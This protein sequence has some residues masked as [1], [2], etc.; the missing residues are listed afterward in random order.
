MAQTSFGLNRTNS[1]Y[2]G[3]LRQAGRVPLPG[4]SGLGRDCGTKFYERGRRDR[5]LAPEFD[6]IEHMGEKE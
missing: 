6:P 5:S 3:G 4:L 2:S 1:L